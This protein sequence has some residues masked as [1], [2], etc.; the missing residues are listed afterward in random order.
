MALEP[1]QELQ[2]KRVLLVLE[3]VDS[4]DHLELL[5]G[6]RIV[7]WFG[8]GSRIIITTENE[9]IFQ[10]SHVMNGVE[11]ETHCI[12]EGDII[13]INRS[14]KEKNVV[15]FVKDFIDVINQLREED[16]MRRNV[17]S[18]VGMGGSGKTT[19]ARIVYDSNEVRKVFPCRAWATV[20]KDYREKKVFSSLVRSLMSS[21]THITENEQE[22]KSKVRI[23]LNEKR[24]KYLVVLDDVWDA[25]VWNKL[26]DYLLPKHN[27]GSR[28]LV[29]TRNVRVANYVGSKEP[30]HEPSRLN[31][32]K[33]W[34][35]K[36]LVE[37][38]VLLS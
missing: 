30:H 33:G 7:D 9:Y 6:M 26:K 12:H 19:L 8:P 20:S 10:N 34:A 35:A 3:G 1:M 16:S 24:R 11:L 31:G 21:S 38:C 4:K 18:I 25:Q 5:E 15:E 29:T 37:K 14:V 23:H 2:Y 27:N 17:I 28:I 13:G 32:E 36:C 22:L